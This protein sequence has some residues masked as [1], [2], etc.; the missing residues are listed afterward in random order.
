MLL[1]YEQE[2]KMKIEINSFQEDWNFLASPRYFSYRF[3]FETQKFPSPLT[4][5]KF[6]TS[7]RETSVDL[8][9]FRTM[10]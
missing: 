6:I 2:E 5:H 10:E 8:L 4:F 1:R 9:P 3:D 7:L